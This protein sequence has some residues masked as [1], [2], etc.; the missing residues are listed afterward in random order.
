[1][2]V[3]LWMSIMSCIDL[4]IDMMEVKGTLLHSLE[5]YLVDSMYWS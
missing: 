2:G 5:D 4:K 3:G 1:M